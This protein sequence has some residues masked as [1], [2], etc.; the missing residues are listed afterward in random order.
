MASNLK[1]PA[2]LMEG[3]KINQSLL[4]DFWKINAMHTGQTRLATKFPAT[5]VTEN[6]TDAMT[7]LATTLNTTLKPEENCTEYCVGTMQEI[8][9]EYRT[10]HHGYVSLIVSCLNIYT[11]RHSILIKQCDCF[12]DLCFRNDCEYS[13]YNHSN[14]KGNVKNSNQFNFEM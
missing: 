8:S 6:F 9:N 5:L 10:Y 11:S 1:L 12:S 2:D 13:Q 4:D 7:T 14:Q 3:L